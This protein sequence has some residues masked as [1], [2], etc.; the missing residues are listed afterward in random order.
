MAKKERKT[1]TE[2]VLESGGATADLYLATAS[3]VYSRSFYL[4]DAVGNV[5][6]VSYL[7]TTTMSSAAATIVFQQSF[8]QPTTEGAVDVTFI[9]PSSLSAHVISLT[10]TSGVWMHRALN[11]S[12]TLNMPVMPWGRFKVQGTGLNTGSTVNIKI[13]KQVEG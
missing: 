4:G 9:E 1:V 8:Q 6:N 11:T 3:V 13:T 10:T 2:N 12:A 7:M 5:I